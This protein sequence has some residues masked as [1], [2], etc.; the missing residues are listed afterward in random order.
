MDMIKIYHNNRCSK[1]R[2]G[3]EILETSGKE[4]EVV[5]YLEQPPSIS[6]L[7]K[8]INLLNIKPIQLVRKNE[9]VW[10]ENYKG[11]ELSDTAIMEAMV[12][13]PKL[14]ERPIVINGNKATI[15]RPPENIHSIL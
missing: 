13:Y 7:T 5:K 3:L 11:K 14:I 12:E 15:G 2:S 8:I 10:K 1:S 6:E 4:F 9:A